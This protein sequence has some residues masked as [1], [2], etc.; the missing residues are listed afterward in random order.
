VLDLDAVNK[1]HQIIKVSSSTVWCHA[2]DNAL[3]SL[4]LDGPTHHPWLLY[5]QAGLEMFPTSAF[6]VVL[7]ANFMIDVLG[8][9]QS[10]SRRIEVRVSSL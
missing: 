3:A 9:S 1:A 10:G 6:M 7:H 5:L 8:V 4:V 2:R